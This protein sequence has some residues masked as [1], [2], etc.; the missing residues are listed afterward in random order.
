MDRTSKKKQA[1]MAKVAVE[2]VS[3]TINYGLNK[4]KMEK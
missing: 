3:M 1:E 4:T 2:N